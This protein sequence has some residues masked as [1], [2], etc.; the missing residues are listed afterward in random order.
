MATL[1]FF[2]AVAG[3]S[4]Y[5]VSQIDGKQIRAH[6]IP[7]SKLVRG[8]VVPHAALADNVSHLL[9]SKSRRRR[10]GAQVADGSPGAHVADAGSSSLVTLSVGQSAA[11][12]QQD[13]FTITATC[14][15]E[16]NGV[17]RAALQASASVDGWYANGGAQAAGATVPLVQTTG[18]GP[19]S[20]APPGMWFRAPAGQSLVV[21]AVFSVHQI[22]DCSFELYGIG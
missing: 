10:H 20:G 6:S 1:A 11:V 13:P 21:Q 2:M 17:F 8:A 3:G 4:A 12:I 5:A 14:T 18:S 22:G 9:V 19:S 7:V 15:D 16:G